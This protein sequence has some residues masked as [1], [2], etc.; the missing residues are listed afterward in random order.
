M[1]LTA[2]HQ[3]TSELPV[4]RQSV[5]EFKTSFTCELTESVFLTWIE[6]NGS[7]FAECLSLE[8]ASS[9]LFIKTQKKLKEVVNQYSVH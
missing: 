7:E 6:H 2:L 3:V 4:T 8:S 9:N 5:N 1:K